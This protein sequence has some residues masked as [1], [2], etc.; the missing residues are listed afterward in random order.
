MKRTASQVLLTTCLLLFSLCA[1][2]ADESD[3]A[4]TTLGGTIP[5]L[6]QIA[7]TNYGTCTNL[8][9]LTVDVNAEGQYD[10]GYATSLG[11]ATVM[12]CDSNKSAQVSV[13]R[14]ADWSCPGAYDKDETDLLMRVSNATGGGSIQNSWS[15]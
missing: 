11:N 10:Q 15:P 9:D 14:S 4:E 7:I 5:E 1:Q 12:W 13:R 2:A 8:L 6:C 3:T